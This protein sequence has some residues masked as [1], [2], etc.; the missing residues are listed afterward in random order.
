MVMEL[1]Y[2]HSPENTNVATFSY[3]G[4]I[5]FGPIYH[6]LK[7][8][9]FII[10]DRYFSAKGIWSNDSRFFVVEEWV[11]IKE[12]EGPNMKLVIFDLEKNKESVVSIVNKGF[13]EPIT[14]Q[15]NKIIYK[16]ELRKLGVVKEL[17]VLINEIK[18][19]RDIDL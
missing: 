19:W 5:R 6:S 4:E 18:N 17:E 8:N 3:F 15:E 11:T 13:F 9:A 14:F 7:I 16:K 12:A 10:K 1:T 2:I